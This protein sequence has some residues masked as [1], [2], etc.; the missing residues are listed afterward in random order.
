MWYVTC[1]CYIY[2]STLTSRRLSPYQMPLIFSFAAWARV[3]SLSLP[4]LPAPSHTLSLSLLPQCFSPL[5]FIALPSS[6]FLSSLP[7][8]S[9]LSPCLLSISFSPIFPLSQF[10]PIIFF[11]SSLFSSSPISQSFYCIFLQ[12]SLN[13]SYFFFLLLI[14]FSLPPFS[15]FLSFSPSPLLAPSKFQSF[16]WPLLCS[17]H[18]P[19]LLSVSVKPYPVHCL[20]VKGLLFRTRCEDACFWKGSIVTLGEQ[21][22]SQMWRHKDWRWSLCCQGALWP[23]FWWWW[24]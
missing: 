7:V 4:S 20:L 16:P 11:L 18:P 22:S 13:H 19:L 3:S 12:F 23:C 21:G 10:F 17:S 15:L 6:S 8:F 14:P 24:A 5:L 9:L 2:F 1:S